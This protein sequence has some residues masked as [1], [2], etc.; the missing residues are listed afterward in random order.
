MS[1]VPHPYASA[2]ELSVETRAMLSAA[3]LQWDALTA[4]ERAVLA[5]AEA[6][7]YGNRF[8][9]GRARAVRRLVRR[10]LGEPFGTNCACLTLP[11]Q[12]VR[13]VGIAAQVEVP[14]VA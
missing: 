12:L 3:R 7:V 11:G 6:D 14:D 4:N 13:Q 10:G 2:P 5:A 9:T 8:A 1:R